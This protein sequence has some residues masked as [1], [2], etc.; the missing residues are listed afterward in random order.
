MYVVDVDRL[1]EETTINYSSFFDK[2]KIIPLETVDE[3]LIGRIDNIK[4]TDNYLFILDRSIARKLL[5]FDKNGK[6]LQQ[7]GQSGRGPTEYEG[8]SDFTIN[9]KAKEVLVLDVK[10]RICIYDMETGEFIRSI[11]LENRNSR[12][13]RIQYFEDKIYLNLVNYEKNADS[14]MLKELDYFTGKQTGKFVNEAFNN[15][16]FK[17]KFM[18]EDP[19]FINKAQDKPVFYRQFMDTVFT[20]GKDGVS[21][22]V[23]LTG[24][25][26]ITE[27]I[28]QQYNL[29]SP[30]DILQFIHT[31]IIHQIINFEEYKDFIFIKY[32]KGFF[33]QSLVIDKHHQQIKEVKNSINNFMHKPDKEGPVPTISCIA[34]DGAYG[35]VDP[36]D[37]KY[38]LQ[39]I[40]KSALTPEVENF[41]RNLSEESNPVII[42][43]EFKK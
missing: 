29:S 24:K 18:L 25:N 30:E 27:E 8:I 28:V 23:V 15:K 9:E 21:P 31:D 34:A 11:L 39:L 7:I 36:S 2:M 17:S 13:S 10:P 19:Y 5:V 14:Y 40:G 22:Y 16:A 33:I 43:Y 6:F 41:F 35:V 37:F 20:I 38:Y 12:S 1:K 42:Y 4:V 26:I 3:S 32:L